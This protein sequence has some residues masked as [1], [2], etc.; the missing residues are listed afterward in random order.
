MH[1]FGNSFGPYAVAPFQYQ[2][3]A[4]PPS[5]V[6]VSSARAAVNIWACSGDNLL[7][8][9][10]AA[11]Q[12]SERME[13]SSQTGGGVQVVSSFD[14]ADPSAGPSHRSRGGGHVNMLH[15]DACAR[16]QSASSSLPSAVSAGVSCSAPEVRPRIPMHSQALRTPQQGQPTRRAR[17]GTEAS[18]DAQPNSDGAKVEESRQ[19]S[20]YG[21][22]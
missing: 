4:T 22:R 21:S 13:Y 19:L 10:P 8:H 12:H 2:R 3:P 11:D 18:A 1:G 9:N 20:R 6:R 15:E 17:L 16:L 5:L 7:Q 14:R